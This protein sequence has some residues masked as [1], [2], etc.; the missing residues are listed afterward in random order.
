MAFI[1]GKEAL[2]VNV[3]LTQMEIDLINLSPTFVDQLLKY[4][5]QV[6]D[7]KIGPIAVNAKNSG[8]HWDP[9][10]QVI[11][12]GKYGNTTYDQLD[13]RIFVGVLAHEIGHYINDP[14]DKAMDAEFAAKMRDDFDVAAIIGVTKEAEAAYNN[15]L[16]AREIAERGGQ[17]IT[18]LGDRPDYVTTPGYDMNGMLTKMYEANKGTLS[19]DTLKRVMIE[20]AGSY[21][22]QT[23]PGGTPG[24]TYYQVYGSSYGASPKH[25]AQAPITDLQ[26]SFDGASGLLKTITFTFST[27][28]QQT[29]QYDGNV[30]STAALYGANGQLVQHA[31]YAA[32][33]FKTQDSFFVNGRETQQYN[34]SPDKSYTKYDFSIDGSQTASL[35]GVNGQMNE[36][37]KFNASGIKTLHSF[38]VNGSETQQYNFNLDKSYTK[39]DFS[40]DGSQTASLYGVNGQITE[41]V[42]FNASGI[43]TL[44]SF[45]VN[46]RETQQYNFNLDKSYTKY[47]FGIDGSQTA[48]LYSVNGQMTEHV[49]FNASGM[50]T[51]DSFYV[52]GQETQQYKFNLDKS[53]T[54]YDFSIDGSQT[55]SLY[56]AN[57]QMTEYVKFNA[58]GIKTLDSFYVNGKETQQYNFN[59][60][61]SYTKYDFNIDG[62]QTASLYGANGQMTEYAKFNPSGFQ[63]QDSL[64]VNGKE[65]QQYKFN[66]DNSYTKYDF[67]L[68]GSQTASLYGVNGQMNEYATFNAS[69]YKTQD[70]FYTNGK[71]TQQYNFNLDNSYTKYDFS[72]NGSQT[73]TFVGANGQVTEYAMFNAG[74]FKTKDVFYGADQ[75]ATRQLE[76]NLDGSYTSHAFNAD[77]SQF[78]A[79]FGTNGL[80]T[81]YASFSADGF[82]TQDI[83]YTNGKATKQYDFSVDNSYISHT[84]DGAKEYIA[85]YGSNHI[86]YDYSQ[87]SQNWM[88]ERDFFDPIGRQ[89]EADR[90]DTNGQLR[91]FTKYT[92]NNDGS[93][94]SN[95]YSSTGQMTA[96][97]KFTGDGAV[98][99]NNNIYIPGS[100]Y[101]F[102]IANAGWSF[103]I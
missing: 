4:N 72:V 85:L 8:I 12:F 68:N 94:W 95:N 22:A 78:A 45:Y 27:G 17:Q 33:G 97:T 81:K 10:G 80:I 19:A 23:E 83:S 1:N 39:Y 70:I 11:E 98:I 44:D 102:P 99:Q 48:S 31:T 90:Y 28:Q 60:D 73:A 67:N 55:A 25:L 71:A 58:S 96:Q 41:Y 20:T 62:S 47:D 69:G 52:N 29:S 5:R 82:K 6:V 91:S 66:L 18:V 57:G 53:Y 21:L 7:N 56:G 32:G 49:K 54:K 3:K 42:K 30:L 63:M 9:N 46:G 15:W 86:I 79:L 38:Y 14:R 84:F 35:Y 64:Y 16:V 13:P 34:F 40:I 87:Y 50:K 93:Y 74:G 101:G 65:T 89:I 26:Y 76:F 24:M 100:G 51:L 59:L 77:G 37:V 36:Y 75:K 92:Y 43:K 2:F 88:F 103:Q 61:K